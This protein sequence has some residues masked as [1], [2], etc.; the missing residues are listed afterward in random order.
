MINAPEITPDNAYRFS[1]V[2]T[3]QTAD[4]PVNVLGCEH[5][6]QEAEALANYLT[7]STGRKH[8]AIYN[9]PDQVQAA[10]AIR[11]SPPPRYRFREEA[12][13]AMGIWRAK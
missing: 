12:F 8:V 5:C 3:I 2:Y 7:S 11:Q 10:K 9:R 6:R 1:D 4:E 13:Q